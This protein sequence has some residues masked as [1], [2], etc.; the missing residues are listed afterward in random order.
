MGKLNDHADYVVHSAHHTKRLRTREVT[1]ISKLEGLKPVAEKR[2]RSPNFWK[3][4]R[5][6]NF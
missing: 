4:E 2:G 5:L 1:V 3:R 6:L